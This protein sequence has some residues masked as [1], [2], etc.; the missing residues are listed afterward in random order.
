MIKLLEHAL[1][2]ADDFE[3]GHHRLSDER[4]LDETRS[5]QFTVAKVIVLAKPN[6]MEIRPAD[7]RCERRQCDRAS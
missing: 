3:D 2:L 5:Q 6:Q 7:T 1:M 4:A